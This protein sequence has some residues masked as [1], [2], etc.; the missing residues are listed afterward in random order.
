[1][2]LKGEPSRKWAPRGERSTNDVSRTRNETF[3]SL[4]EISKDKHIVFM[5]IGR[6]KPLLV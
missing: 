4:R 6:K 3:Q 1:M 5:L 2:F